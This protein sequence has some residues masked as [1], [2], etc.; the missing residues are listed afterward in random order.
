MHSDRHKLRWAMQD[1]PWISQA[2]VGRSLTNTTK[3]SSSIEPLQNSKTN[4]TTP[5]TKTTTLPTL[6]DAHSK[7]S[8]TSQPQKPSRSDEPDPVASNV[9]TVKTVQPSLRRH[10]PATQVKPTQATA[11]VYTLEKAN[12]VAV[13]TTTPTVTV[14]HTPRASVQVKPKSKGKSAQTHGTPSKAANARSESIVEAGSTIET[15]STYSGIEGEKPPVSS[16]SW[17]NE[18]SNAVQ[19]DAALRGSDD[20]D[21]EMITT[22][23]KSC[24]TQSVTKKSSLL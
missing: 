16:R 24:T 22:I 10:R 7:M 18:A 17:S 2:E 8:R 23:E 5:R 20:E 14:V 3:V 12:Q 9:Q 6:M 4:A 11:P 13:E 21:D 15:T 1:I 19:E